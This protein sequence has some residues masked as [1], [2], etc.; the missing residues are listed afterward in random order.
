ML[1]VV[2][3]Y[4]RR[5]GLV[6]LDSDP[7]ATRRGVTSWVIRV[8]YEAFLP[9]IM[10]KG[11]EFIHDRASQYRGLIIRDILREMGIRVIE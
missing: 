6:P 1:W 4:N 5:I 8:V 3:G 9:E 10:V 7:E 2:F 11:R